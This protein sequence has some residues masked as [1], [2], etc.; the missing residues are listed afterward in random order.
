[1]EGLLRGGNS[2]S[3]NFTNKATN[4]HHVW[5]TSIPEH[6]IGGYSL[7][8]AEAWA[9][10]ITSAIRNGIYQSYAD[11][12]LKGTDLG[13]PVSSALKWAVESNSFI[14]TT[15]L[16]MGVEG[17]TGMELSGEYYEKGIQ[18]V[19]VQIAKAGLRYVFH[20]CQYQME[21]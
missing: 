18:V 3:V 4:L 7:P 20:S 19:Q 21:Y 11:E 9:R 8:Y 1:M 16:P 15:V 5:D 14:C 13:D 2:I 17:I 10:N 12:W 6:F